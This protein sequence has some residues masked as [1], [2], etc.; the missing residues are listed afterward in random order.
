M[1]EKYTREDHE[2]YRRQVEAE[3][4]RESQE[5]RDAVREAAKRQWIADGGNP[6]SFDK[7]YD[8]LADSLAADAAR[9][10]EQAARATHRRVSTI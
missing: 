10:R 2:A 4:E 9:K 1:S 7:A 3:Q 8:G 6:Q 5:R